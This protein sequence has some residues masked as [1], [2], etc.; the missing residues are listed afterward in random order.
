MKKI[1]KLIPRSL[2]TLATRM[3]VPFFNL[4]YKTLRIRFDTTDASVF[5][6]IFIYGDLKLPPSLKPTVIL[7]AG[8]YVGYSTLYFAHTYPEATII[9]VEPEASNFSQLELHT[10]HLPHVIRVRGGLWPTHTKLKITDRGTGH[11]GFRVTEV[12]GDSDYDVQG[13]TVLD[14]LSMYQ[15][16]HL[17][18]LKL[19]IEGSEKELFSRN[20]D[21]WLRLTQ[22]ILVEF[23]ERIVPGCTQTVQKAFLSESW[24]MS[25]FGEKFLFERT[26]E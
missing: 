6:D 13:Y 14:I 7:D 22:N 15:L 24:K 12:P 5:R 9:A 20:Y 11:W 8:A 4:K 26:N 25:K 19:D 16:S 23:H 21:E 10:K 18:L 3:L 2:I 17:D 1:K